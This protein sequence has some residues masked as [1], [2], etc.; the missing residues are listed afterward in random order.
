MVI[1]TFSLARSI[2]EQ[3]VRLDA[4][5]TAQLRSACPVDIHN[6]EADV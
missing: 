3:T 2:W 6:G 4:E 1:P 5:Y